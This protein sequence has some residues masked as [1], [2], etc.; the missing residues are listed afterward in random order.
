[1][2]LLWTIYVSSILF[3]LSFRARLFIDALRS[4][5]ILYIGRSV[6][7]ESYMGYTKLL[8]NVAFRVS[9]GKFIGQISRS[10]HRP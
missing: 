9:Q 10:G 5:A 6:W 1:M 2:L 7:P 8:Q 3:L 4:H